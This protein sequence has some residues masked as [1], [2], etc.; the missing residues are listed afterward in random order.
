ME[1]KFGAL[2]Y[3]AFFL[4]MLG[5]WGYLMILIIRFINKGIKAL[6]IYIKKNESRDS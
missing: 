5:V 3:Q 2:I 4:I 1:F 6:D